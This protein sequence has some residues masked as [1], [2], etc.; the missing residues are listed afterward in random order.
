MSKTDAEW[1]ALGTRIA[2]KVLGWTKWDDLPIIARMAYLAILPRKP[3]PFRLARLRKSWWSVSNECAY[4]ELF[5]A[6][7]WQPHKNVAQAMKVL[8]EMSRRCKG[9][10]HNWFYRIQSYPQVSG[11]LYNIYLQKSVPCEGSQSWRNLEYSA[12][13]DSREHAIC[14]AM[15]RWLDAQRELEDAETE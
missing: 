11:H 2:R 9:V 7:D 6:F 13:A 5:F 14:L 3:D 12:D 8:D 15:E 10:T 4:I 1:Q